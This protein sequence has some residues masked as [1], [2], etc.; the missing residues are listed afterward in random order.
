MRPNTKK[1]TYLE[2]NKHAILIADE[3]SFIV[4]EFQVSSFKIVK[5]IC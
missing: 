2:V 4:S 3:P 5:F 1:L